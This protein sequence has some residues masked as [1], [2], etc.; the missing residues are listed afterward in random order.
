MF[1]LR[2]STHGWEDPSKSMLPASTT[3]LHGLSKATVTAHQCFNEAASTHFELSILV[4]A[5]SRSPHF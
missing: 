5:R 3:M 1:R 4:Y 2:G